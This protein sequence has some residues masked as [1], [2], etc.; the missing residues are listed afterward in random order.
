MLMTVYRYIYLQP[1]PNAAERTSAE[2]GQRREGKH[3]IEYT[4]SIALKFETHITYILRK[5]KEETDEQV[6]LT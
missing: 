5:L 6:H 3:I 1:S 4:I 2:A